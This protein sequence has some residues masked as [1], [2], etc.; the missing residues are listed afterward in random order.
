MPLG[1]HP[2]K[3]IALIVRGLLL[4]A[5]TIAYTLEKRI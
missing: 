5:C 4:V 2:Q 3:L 1:M